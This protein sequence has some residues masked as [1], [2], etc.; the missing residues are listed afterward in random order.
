MLFLVVI[1]ILVFIL[2]FF[3]VKTV[4]QN[5]I[6]KK[7]MIESSFS[8]E[9]KLIKEQVKL[10][11]NKEKLLLVE[12]LHETLFDSLFKITRDIILMQKLIFE[13]LTN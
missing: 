12:A 9:E 6:L 5:M 4:F 13:K 1:Y 3:V 10:A 11:N 8:L 2:M 7:A